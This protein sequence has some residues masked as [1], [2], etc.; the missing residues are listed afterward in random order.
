MDDF[1]INT[2]I[3]AKNEWS[4]R[5]TNILTPNMIEG[6]K[7]IFDEALELCRKNDEEI[8]YLMTF[9]NLLNNIP[10]WSSET[11]EIEKNRILENSACNYLEDLL[12]CVHIAQLKSLTSTR[13]GIKQKQINI[14]IPNL[15]SFIHKAYTNIARK[16]YTNVYLF[17][18]NI[19]P[20]NIQKN[21]RELELIIKESI[22]NTI[23]DSIP[24]E[25]IL[26]KYIDETQETDVEVTE[27]KETIIDEEELKIQKEKKR[28]E[29]LELLKE[30][31]KKELK[32]ESTKKLSEAIKDLNKNDV[33]SKSDYTNNN[34]NN[35]DDKYDKD[36]KDDYGD[37]IN[38][39]TNE[40]PNDIEL[41]IQ[42]LD[43]D[44]DKL[45][46]DNIKL[47]SDKNNLDLD[48]IELK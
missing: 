15:D 23:R 29:E 30:E 2:I 1:N 43:L 40:M 4:A 9:Q 17:E 48:I 46:M 20:L 39:D 31:A 28:K 16:V 47:D 11:I 18:I 13:V 35:D 14:N 42:D 36:D 21:N 8:K 19:S 45:M 24:I 33:L 34:T 10:K 37:I 7:S 38:I 12:T 6:L 41:D 44:N 26:Q 32:E 27:E 25:D 3:E 5:L 22:L